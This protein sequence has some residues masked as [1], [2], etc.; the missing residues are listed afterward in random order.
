MRANLTIT[1]A[2]QKTA[3][4]NN[5]EHKQLKQNKRQ[6]I[7]VKTTEKRKGKIISAKDTQK[8]QSYHG[9]RKAKTCSF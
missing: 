7:K 2:R 3:E 6:K 1:C 8:D 5:I 9:K 4:D